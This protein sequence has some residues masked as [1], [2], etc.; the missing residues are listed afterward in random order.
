[1]DWKNLKA[2]AQMV[3]TIITVVLVLLGGIAM[4]IAWRRLIGIE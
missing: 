2:Q 1:M 4:W 3:W